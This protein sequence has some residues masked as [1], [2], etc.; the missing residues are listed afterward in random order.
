M[1]YYLLNALGDNYRWLVVGYGSSRPL[2]NNNTET[3]RQ[4]NR[5]VEIAV[6]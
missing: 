1:A 4:L 2:A 6:D 3:Y 5:R